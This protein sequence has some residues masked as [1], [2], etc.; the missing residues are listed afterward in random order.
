MTPAFS[1]RDR[2]P[3]HR[4]FMTTSESTKAQALLLGD[5][6]RS[7]IRGILPVLKA[8]YPPA[9]VTNWDQLD[10]DKKRLEIAF[11]AGQHSLIL[12]LENVLEQPVENSGAS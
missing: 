2:S 10:T 5:I 3:P 1:F 4:R 6:P 11:K 8:C 12:D 7:I 9:N